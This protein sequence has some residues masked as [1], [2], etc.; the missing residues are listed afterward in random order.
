VLRVLSK[1]AKLRYFD[2]IAAASAPLHT[3]I[4]SMA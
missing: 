1:Y 4:P 3:I 2:S